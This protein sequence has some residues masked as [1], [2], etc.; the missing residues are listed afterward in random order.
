MSNN[1]RVG[2]KVVCVDDVPREGGNCRV[3]YGHVYTVA[4]IG[5]STRNRPFLIVA[6][7]DPSPYEGWHRDR[8]RPAVE[9]K[10]DI[11]IFTRMLTDDKVVA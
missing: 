1:F 6:E 7:I 10:T 4:A 2:Q 11:S 5:M 8:F 9:R 3:K